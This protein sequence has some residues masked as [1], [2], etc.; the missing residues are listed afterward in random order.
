M[1]PA[2]CCV[3]VTATGR[4]STSR[5]GGAKAESSASFHCTDPTCAAHGTTGAGGPGDVP[6]CLHPHTCNTRHS[7]T[8]VHL[9]LGDGRTT[10]G[11]ELS[12]PH[13]GG[14]GPATPTPYAAG[15]DVSCPG[16]LEQIALVEV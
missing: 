2:V 9:D 7:P 11:R 16:R 13:P 15:E 12:R 3:N 8:R 5:D 1:S 10:A 14:V 4:R 6:T